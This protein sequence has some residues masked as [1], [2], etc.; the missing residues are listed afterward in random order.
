MFGA[1]NIHLYG[2]CKWFQ[3][4]ITLTQREDISHTYVAKIQPG[5]CRID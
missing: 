5:P 1:F 3:R 2:F 4:V